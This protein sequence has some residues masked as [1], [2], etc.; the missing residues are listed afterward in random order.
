MLRE[1]P[2]LAF[3]ESSVESG[4]ARRSSGAAAVMKDVTATDSTVLQVNF[5]ALL[6]LETRLICFLQGGDEP[7]RRV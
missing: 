7:F 6:C 1:G 3:S 4:K 2:D 5:P